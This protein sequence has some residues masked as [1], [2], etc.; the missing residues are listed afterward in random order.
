MSSQLLA[1]DGWPRSTEVAALVRRIDAI[2]WFRRD[3]A[4]CDPSRR[5]VSAAAEHTRR[6]GTSRPQSFSVQQP[7]EGRAGIR[8]QRIDLS[9]PAWD[10]LL[11]PGFDTAH[12]AI[13]RTGRAKG[14]SLVTVSGEALLIR[15]DALPVEQETLWERL[16]GPPDDRLPPAAVRTL[17]D[18]VLWELGMMVLW[19]MVGDL[20]GENPYEPLLPVYEEGLYPLDLTPA[21]PVLLWAPV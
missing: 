9:R 15:P 21:G 3:S 20:V 10:A 2:N 6:L 5:L 1:E 11:R 19:E 18:R 13:R 4:V 14:H 16:Q 12:S 8:D 17:V 7:W